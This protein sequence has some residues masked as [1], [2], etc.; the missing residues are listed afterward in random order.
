MKYQI[1]KD[2]PERFRIAVGVN[3]LLVK[4]GKC[5]LIRRAN[6]GWADGYYTIPAGHLDGNE[7]LTAAAAR[8][9]KEEVGITIEPSDLTLVHVMHRSDKEDDQERLDFLFLASKW[10]GD[11][12][13]AEP[14]KA[15]E[16]GWFAIDKL[17]DH[18]LENVRRML[19]TY[20]TQ[21]LN[22]V[23]W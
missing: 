19:T 3:V 17:P 18:T 7:P 4:D 11:P 20:K 16:L 21:L 23:N 8:E 22:E 13:I 6:T 5:L 14:D 10:Q 15:D 12:Y 9:V 1:T 2:L